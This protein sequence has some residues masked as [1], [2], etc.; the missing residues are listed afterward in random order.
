MHA[1]LRS[2]GAGGETTPMRPWGA[3]VEHAVDFLIEAGEIAELD[4]APLA[5]PPAA[6]AAGTSRGALPAAAP[7]APAVGVAAVAAPPPAAAP[8]A[9]AAAAAARKRPC[10]D[11]AAADPAPAAAAEA[12]DPSR[13]WIFVGGT[14]MA[15]YRQPGLSAILQDS[16]ARFPGT[17]W[18]IDQAKRTCDIRFGLQATYRRTTTQTS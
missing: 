14:V 16:H 8:A 3:R 5:A 11:R 4:S 7:A 18:S 10:P 13:P 15:R 2:W 12:A 1:V 6:P 9:A 17:V